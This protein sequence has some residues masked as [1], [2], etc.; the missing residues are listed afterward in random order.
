MAMTR[1]AF[2]IVVMAALTAGAAEKGG[3]AWWPQFRGPDAAGIGEGRTPVEFG[4]GQRE[5][6]KAAVGSGLSSPAVWEGRIFLTEFDR[7]N[8][9][10]ATLCL[11]RR[12]GK[13]LWRRTVEAAQI[14][15][16]HEISNPAAPTPATD[17]E[18]VYVYFGSYGLVSYD[19]KGN[20]RWEKRL[21]PAENPYGVAS[22]PIVAGDLV[23]INHQGKDAYLLAVNRRDGR[24][25]WKTDRSLFKFGWSTPVRWRHD[26]IDEIV[27]LG[28]DFQPNQRLMAY[29]LADGAERWWV[30][31]LPPCGKSTPVAGGGLLFFAAPDII[32]EPV[33]IKRN[34]ER[35]EQLY[36]NNHSRVTAVRPGG[37]GEVNETNVAWSEH[38]GTPGVPSPL[39]S[40]GRLYTFLNGGIVYCREA[41]TGKLLYSGRLGAPGDYYSSPVAADGKVYIASAEGE[42]TVLDAGEELKVLARNKLDSGI[43]AT[44]AV[45]DGKIY[46][47]TES[48]LYAFGN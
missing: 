26:G 48:Y 43:L 2:I 3:K 9:Q 31:G 45:A 15:K 27:V 20:P 32:M 47:R 39:Y 13:V 40:K 28:G 11:D 41:Q 22:S 30:A 25:V 6:W 33:A 44:P 14:E 18:R 37:K 38:K 4:P 35:A 29:N 46:V 1:L 24:T 19:L 34:P 42:V 12:T 16:V 7:T 10:L 23:V 17:G 8:R 36:A 5:I 21:P